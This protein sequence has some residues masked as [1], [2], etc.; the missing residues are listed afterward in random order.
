MS[1]S[2]HDPQSL[3]EPRSLT[4]KLHSMLAEPRPISVEQEEQHRISHIG[5]LPSAL[6][7]E[8]IPRDRAKR[9]QAPSPEDFSR[10]PL[11]LPPNA[12]QVSC[13]SFLRATL[14]SN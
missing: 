10:T 11:D 4:R 12:R 7:E 1:T 2:L 6:P 5:L 13:Q 9:S 3:E 8:Y 14:L